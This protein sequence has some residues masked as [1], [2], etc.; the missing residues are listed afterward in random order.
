MVY[1]QIWQHLCR[2]NHSYGLWP[3]WL[4]K[5]LPRFGFLIFQWD[6][7]KTQNSHYDQKGP[8]MNYFI[9]L[10]KKGHHLE[11]FTFI[12]EKKNRENSFVL[13][14]SLISFH[15]WIIN[16]IIPIWFSWLLFFPNKVVQ[17]NQYSWYHQ[18]GSHMNIYI[19]KN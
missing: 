10:N 12:G 13:F 3:L 16:L 1:Y 5:E 11:L 19:F 6:C 14:L 4:H 8:H 15:K 17:Q 2:P 9:F 7:V 18:K